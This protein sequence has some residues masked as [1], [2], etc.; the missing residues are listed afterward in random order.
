MGN[1]LYMGIFNSYVSLPEG[2]VSN[3]EILSAHLILTLST[4]SIP[5]RGKLTLASWL[6]G[7]NMQDDGCV[8]SNTI[9]RFC[10][11]K[12]FHWY[13]TWSSDSMLFP[14]FHEDFVRNLSSSQPNGA[15]RVLAGEGKT[16][17]PVIP[18]THGRPP[19]S[20]MDPLREESISSVIP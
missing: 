18:E 11:S 9:N 6:Q 13:Q 5:Q 1:Q 17:G 14:P 3:S 16:T 2:R 12:L 15:M 19:T 7:G 20:T 4:G 8:F 10:I